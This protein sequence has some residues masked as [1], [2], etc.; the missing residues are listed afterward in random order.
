MKKIRVSCVLVLL[1]GLAG[2]GGSGGDSV[3]TAPILLR[4]VVE[5]GPI[6][7]ATISLR[8]KTGVPLSLCGEQG[9]ALCE[10]KTDGTGSFSLLVKAGTDLADLTVRAVGGIDRDTG[11]DFSELE[12]RSPL[13]RFQG[14]M[15]AIVISPLTTLIAELHDQ[16]VSFSAA[17][18]KLRDWLGLPAD[19][20]LAARPTLR[21][22]L[23]VQTLLLSRIA[24]EVRDAD[25]E[26][27]PFSAICTEMLAVETLY[28][29]IS[30]WKVMS[31]LGLK[32]VVQARIKNL[33]TLLTMAATVE[34]A[35]V[36]YKRA[37]L[38][39]VFV[40]NIEQMLID[41]LSFDPQNSN[42]LANL[43]FLAETT[44]QASGSEVITLGGTI[45]QRV[46]R[47]ILFTYQLRTWE[48][49]TLDPALFVAKLAPLAI[50][51]WI[52]E[53]ARSRSLY[54]V[55]SPLLLT[56]LPGNDN[57]H[58]LAYFY[59]SDL[60][61]HYQAEQLIGQVFDDAINDAVLLKIIEGKANAGLIE[62]TKAIIATQI[63]QSEPKAHAYR[64]LA[65]ALIKSNRPH[66]A[67]EFLDLARDL[68]RKV[69]AAKGTSSAS[70]TDVANLLATASSYRKAGDLL[71]AE[72][73]LLDDI[74][75][76][77]TAL[78][79]DA[80][81]YG[82]LIT[83]IKNVADAYI[84]DGDLEAAAPLVEK[85]DYYSGLTP[86]YLSTYK[87]RIFNLSETAK[88]YA[89][90]GDNAMVL[91]VFSRIQELRKVEGSTEATY[92]APIISLIESLY[93][94]GA[95]DEALA[96][97]ST[98]PDGTT[99]QSKVFKLVATY[100]ALQGNMDT[101][102]SIVDN[103]SYVPR[104]EDRIDLLTYF[105]SSRPYIGQVLINNGRFN[106]ARQA[107]EKAKS[108]LDGMILSNNLARISNGYV[109]VAELYTQMGS[110]EDVVKA[111]DLL[112]SAQNAMADD[113][114][115]VTALADIALGY[116]N[117]EEP[118]VALT[119][120]DHAKSLADADP[121]HY[122]ANVT[123]GLGAEEYAAQL[124]EKLVKSYEEIGD[125]LRVR[126]TTLSFQ[127]WV[128]KIHTAGTVDDKLAIKECVY[129]LRAVLYLDRAGYH[130]E[131]V[132]VL[133]SARELTVGRVENNITVYDIVILKDRLA[134]CLGV[135][136]TYAAVHEYEKALEL[137][138][139]LEYTS[140]R[141]QAIQTLANA[142]I[143]RDD[144]P[145]IWVA[146]ID[147]D[148]D[149]QP[150]FF[151]PL[152]SENEIAASGLILDDDS[153]GDGIPDSEDFRPLFADRL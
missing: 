63:I 34:E 84:A 100:E 27:N 151:N 153:D 130:V 15:A 83:G 149:G 141:N 95:R 133:N 56:E 136:T 140:E 143:D 72:S 42:Y 52:A 7:D 33:Q 94:V 36:I 37:E 90:I 146:S 39:D 60:S 121:A 59:N 129:L 51:P 20:N 45:P 87:L 18:V 118:A 111:K 76:I 127:S 131:A 2:C 107:L 78:A 46:A 98:I 50:D 48:S 109:R 145:N 85:M 99:D 126:T 92:W 35:V 12:M 25:K 144:F 125:N 123:S 96:L 117:L 5:D 112:Q 54:S 1:L 80:I 122:R 74:A 24:F 103:S 120:L 65:N 68:Y 139:S 6:G 106:E 73:L 147:S 26:T 58:R 69:L 119:L 128:K 81:I 88:R 19:A 77:A 134:N 17:E 108:I 137:A 22:D 148:G 38:K 49:L 62:E 8:D 16:G 101:A 132:D 9:A 152:A 71:N 135:I 11:I 79:S 105:N 41:S 102:F 57:Q 3:S 97:A 115:V 61:P 23:Q 55:V 30:D 64:A 10:T 43:E 86:A 116:H 124:Y 93:H 150:D 104:D 75:A 14:N 31:A 44:L 82:K 40:V 70:A 110:S 142:Y 21:R 47:Y 114:Y 113:L 89:D 29:A 66:E 91:D 53:L 67:R 28:A 138:L 13:E 32:D 4:G